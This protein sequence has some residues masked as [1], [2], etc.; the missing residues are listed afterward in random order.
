MLASTALSAVLGVVAPE[1]SQQVLQIVLPMLGAIFP[2]TAAMFLNPEKETRSI[3]IGRSFI[4][5]SVAAVLPSILIAIM[6]ES[7]GQWRV[8]GNLPAVLV[9]SGVVIAPVTYIMSKPLF[10]KLYE[11]ADANAEQALRHVERKIGIENDGQ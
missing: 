3:V 6:P 11:R 2:T 9:G 4:A 1:Q 7:W 10:R 5:F 8:V